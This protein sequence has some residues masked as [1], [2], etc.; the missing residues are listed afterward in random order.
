MLSTI[1]VFLRL[2]DR[3]LARWDLEGVCDNV[4]GTASRW[5]FSLDIGGIGRFEENFAPL[6]S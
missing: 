4:R 1:C 3:L 2:E 5:M 6:A